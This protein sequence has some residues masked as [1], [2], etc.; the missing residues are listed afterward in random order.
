MRTCSVTLKIKLHSSAL[1]SIAW[2]FVAS[3]IQRMLS[4]SSSRLQ[5]SAIAPSMEGVYHAKV[6][7]VS[8][9]SVDVT[10]TVV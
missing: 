10:L 1:W 3:Q 8:G 5:V 4:Q 6:D 9:A 2:S 7:T